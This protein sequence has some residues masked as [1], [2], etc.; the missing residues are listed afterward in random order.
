LGGKVKQPANNRPL[1]PFARDRSL[2]TIDR[3]TKAGRVLRQVRACSATIRMTGQRQ[4]G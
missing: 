2:T 3:R 4:S 1:G